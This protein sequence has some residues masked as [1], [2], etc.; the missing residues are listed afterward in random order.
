MLENQ[1]A[2]SGQKVRTHEE[3][4]VSRSQEAAEDIRQKES[5]IGFGLSIRGLQNEDPVVQEVCCLSD[6]TPAGLPPFPVQPYHAAS[7][8]EVTEWVGVPATCGSLTT[9]VWTAVYSLHGAFPGIL[10]SQPWQ[11]ERLIPILQMGK[12]VF[13]EVMRPLAG[14]GAETLSQVC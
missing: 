5:I 13:R 2:L 3:K 12:L 9:D 14:Q 8:L 4:G 7:L 10:S 1:R 11:R 6:E